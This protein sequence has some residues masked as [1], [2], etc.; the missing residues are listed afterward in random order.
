[1]PLQ[2][3]DNGTN[4][5]LEISEATRAAATGSITFMGNDSVVSVTDP[6]YNFGVHMTLHHRAKVIIG[7]N[8]NAKNLFVHAADGACVLIGAGGSFNG[9]VRLLLHEE[10][11]ISIGEN[12]LFASEVDVTISDMHSIVDIATG[13]RLNYPR[14]V[15]IGDKVWIGQRA[16]VLKGVTIGAG[17]IVG[18]G[19]V[20]T[21][22]VPGQC[23]V[24]GNP[25]QLVKKG[26]TWTFQL[27]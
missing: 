2:V 9:L 4:N 7:K 3:T 21:K 18:A 24:A 1:M 16:L 8:F 12:C 22:D 27:M 5:R 10:G 20:V 11:V 25:A 19:A 23:A 15:V 14:N 26:V 17:A 6:A 13:E